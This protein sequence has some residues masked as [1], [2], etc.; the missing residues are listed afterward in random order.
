MLEQV[1]Q[2]LESEVMR[3]LVVDLALAG[4]P[5]SAS[6]KDEERALMFSRYAVRAVTLRYLLGSPGLRE[7]SRRLAGSERLADFCGCRTLEGIRWTS[8]STLDRAL[9]LFNEESVRLLQRTLLELTGQHDGAATLGLLQPLALDTCLID[10]TCLEANIHFPTDWVLLSD[11]GQTLLKAITLIRRE[12]LRPRMP[13]GPGELARQLNVCCMEMSQQRRRPDARRGRKRILR[14]LKALLRQIDGH[15]ARHRERLASDW[16]DTGL[17]EARAH[18]IL[19]R[20]DRYRAQVPAVI[21]QAHERIIGE[22]QV[23][24][25]DKILSAHEADLHTLVRGKAGKEVEFGNHLH[26]GESS[27]GLIVDWE[28]YQERPPSDTQQLTGMVERLQAWDV[29]QPLAAI[30]GDRAYATAAARRLLERNGLYDGL[31]PRPTAELTERQKEPRFRTL[32]RRRSGIEAR[33]ATLK[34]RLLGGRFRAK[35]FHNRSLQLGWAIFAHNLHQLVLIQ[36][37]QSMDQQSAA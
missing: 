25:A 29:D 4:L 5:A 21:H 1:D 30:S 3:A 14:R 16:R 18:R 36:Q 26:L 28:L 31:C 8:K 20:M 7:W 15:A 23:A 2:M 34:H 19:E 13:G 17:S 32:Q 12:G 27:E 6:A 10:A 11:V 9:K 24:E 37:R 33:I 35:G 22:R